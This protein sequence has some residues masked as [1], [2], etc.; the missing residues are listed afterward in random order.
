[1]TTYKG[2][3]LQNG[4]ILAMKTNVGASPRYFL[5][6]KEISIADYYFY[7]TEDNIEKNLEVVQSANSTYWTLLRKFFR[8][9]K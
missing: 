1:M 2:T 8:F 3:P 7:L 6:D 9:G 5:N 4:D